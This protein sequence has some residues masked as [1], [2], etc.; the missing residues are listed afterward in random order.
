M[1][2]DKVNFLKKDFVQHVRTLDNTTPALFGKMNPWQMI[3]HM[4]D[5]FRNANQKVTFNILTPEE[6]LKPM[7]DFLMSEKDFK[8]NTP[9][10]LMSDTPAAY[11]NAT[12]E[13]AILE[14]E[15]EIND[16]IKYFEENPD[17]TVT[18]P[19]FGHLNYEEWVQLLHK[20]ALHHL[21]QFGVLV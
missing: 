19:F 21:R 15:G 7:K 5:A 11:R 16:F 3:E 6:R 2:S 10:A 1:N 20:H 13:S 4:S 17:S 9:N 8:P 18:N 14:L 12:I